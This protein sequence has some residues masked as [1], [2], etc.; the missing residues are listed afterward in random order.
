MNKD[1]N[2]LYLESMEIAYRMISLNDI[3]E[4]MIKNRKG[5]IKKLASIEHILR[6]IEDPETRADLLQWAVSNILTTQ[7]WFFIK[8][9]KI[10]SLKDYEKLAEITCAPLGSPVKDTHHMEMGVITEVGEIIDPIKKW[11]AYNKELDLINVQE[12]FG[13]LMWYLINQC[14]LFGIVYEDELIPNAIFP[15]N[16]GS[17]EMMVWEK[18]R[19][20]LKQYLNGAGPMYVIQDIFDICH[21]MRWDFWQILT[22]NIDKLERRFKGKFDAYYA[23]NRDLNKE[24]KELEK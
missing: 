9:T 8:P 6:N 7:D 18:T 3:D 23:I 21:A 1:T 2:D 16:Y 15:E 19:Q 10:H 17:N 22:N 14:R 5:L 11:F 24:R 12:E 20:L 4:F 13:D